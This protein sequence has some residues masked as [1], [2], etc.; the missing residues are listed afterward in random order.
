MTIRKALYILSLIVFLTSFGP[1]ILTE[2]VPRSNPVAISLGEAI[3]LLT[4]FFFIGGI[5]L[6]L[7]Q[8]RRR[9]AGQDLGYSDAFPFGL[10]IIFG[11]LMTSGQGMHLSSNSL[12]H[13]LSERNHGDIYWL[14][15][16]YDEVISHYMWHVGAFGLS[17]AVALYQL[18]YPL[19]GP[20]V[21]T[22]SLLPAA[23]LVAFTFAFASTEGE[24]IPAIM[25]MTLIGLLG[26]MTVIK[27]RGLSLAQRPMLMFSILYYVLMLLAWSAYAIAFGGFM[28]PLTL[29]G[30]G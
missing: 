4:P 2:I 20:S 15:Y 21:S 23:V 3:D 22:L 5:I 14:N 16:L 17:A 28:P 9:R 10:A 18:K 27:L 13:F 25:P 6:V 30:R 7:E 12:S 19:K 8:I 11:I 24:T 29:L 1:P 26:Y